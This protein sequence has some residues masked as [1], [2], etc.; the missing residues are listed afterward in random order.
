MLYRAAGLVVACA[1]VLA[2]LVAVLGVSLV[3]VQGRSSVMAR[4]V[5]VLNGNIVW[6]SLMIF[7]LL[8]MAFVHAPS[9]F[10]TEKLLVERCISEGSA[11]VL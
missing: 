4:V 2:E 10:D 6:T 11:S 3:S 8:V 5:L 1:L 7:E 9:V